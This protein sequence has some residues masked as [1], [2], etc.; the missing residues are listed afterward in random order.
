MEILDLSSPSLPFSFF[1]AMNWASLPHNPYWGTLPQHR[2]K[3][4]T[5]NQ[6]C[7]ETRSQSKSFILISYLHFVTAMGS[8]WIH[9]SRHEKGFLCFWGWTSKVPFASMVILYI[10]TYTFAQLHCPRV[11]NMVMFTQSMCWINYHCFPN[12]SIVP[13]CRS[14]LDSM[15]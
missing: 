5:A 6:L 10:A 4:N 15:C 7:T 12:A 14:Y 11:H 8:Q 1:V 2:L 9:L 3:S 13:A